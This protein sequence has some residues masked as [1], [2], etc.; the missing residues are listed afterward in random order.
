MVPDMKLSRKLE[1][2]L[3]ITILEKTDETIAE[4]V[5]SSNVRG[6]TIGDIARIK[7]N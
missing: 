1:K 3:G 7:K 6:A 5:S 4:E 2:T